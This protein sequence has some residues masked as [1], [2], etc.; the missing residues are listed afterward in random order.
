MSGDLASI[1]DMQNRLRRLDQVIAKQMAFLARIP[2]P[3][4]RERADGHLLQ[5]ID[6]R[7]DVSRRYAAAIGERDAASTR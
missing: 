5:L 7:E 4:N 1:D 3:D 6:M 2:D